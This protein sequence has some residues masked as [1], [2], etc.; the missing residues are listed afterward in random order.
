LKERFTFIT[1]VEPSQGRDKTPE[2]TDPEDLIPEAKIQ[3]KDSNFS[4]S[5]QKVDERGRSK[6]VAE[7]GMGKSRERVARRRHITWE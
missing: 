2:V 3:S 7:G 6:K 4:W 5:A 1:Q